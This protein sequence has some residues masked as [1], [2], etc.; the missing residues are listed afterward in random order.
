MG[1]R[2]K[3]P[4]GNSIGC[5]ADFGFIGKT[6]SIKNSKRSLLSYLATSCPTT[7]PTAAPPIVPRALP[8]VK[9]APPTAPMPAPTAVLLPCS[10]MPE[11]PLSDISM[12]NVT[13]GMNKNLYDVMTVPRV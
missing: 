11:H 13:V 5:F 7:P 4:T 6:L 9:T 8:P 10:D 3:W 1:L 12:M 2:A